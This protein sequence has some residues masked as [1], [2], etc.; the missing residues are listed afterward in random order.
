MK[1]ST[2]RRARI[3]AQLRQVDDYLAK[4]LMRAEEAAA[5][6]Q[7]LQRQLLE[8][9]MPDA[10]APR[11]AWRA[12]FGAAGAMALLVFLVFAYLMWGNAGLNVRT[13]EMLKVIQ[14]REAEASGTVAAVPAATGPSG[15]AVVDPSAWVGG[16]VELSAPLASLVAPDASVFI[17]LRHPGEDGMPLAS[18]RK[19]ADD[20]PIDFAIG[21]KD[22]LGDAA[23]VTGSSAPVVVEVRVSNSGRGLAQPGDL[24]GHSEPLP[25]GAR[26]I[27]VRVARVRSGS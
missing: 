9:L 21:P 8:A 22:A 1:D 14:H 23:R 27:L 6:R 4:G 3:E 26:A 2:D 25:V 12:R 7:A 19:R 10:P 24:E 5:Q 15:S 11:P 13:I 18:V 16:R 17:T 20:L